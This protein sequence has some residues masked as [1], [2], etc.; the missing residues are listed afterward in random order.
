MN[1]AKPG[2]IKNKCGFNALV[3]LKEYLDD[4]ASTGVKEAGYCLIEKAR[5]G[6]DAQIQS[7]LD[8]VFHE[9]D[10]GARDLYV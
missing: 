8:S 5:K 6:F 4:F 9:V 10:G 3:T 1:L 2:L 7:E